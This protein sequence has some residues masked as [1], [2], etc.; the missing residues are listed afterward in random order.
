MS[1]SKRQYYDHLYKI[2][3]IGVADVGKTSLTRVF[4]GDD[5]RVTEV[6]TVQRELFTTYMKRGKKSIKI[7][8]YDT[9]GSE[10]YA[11]LT[12]SYLRA[13]SGILLVY[14]VNN[15]KSLL[16]SINLYKKIK[17]DD[18]DFKPSI[19]LVGSKSDL[20]VKITGGDIMDA[21]RQ[22]NNI[23]HVITSAKTGENL[24][25]IFEALIDDILANDLK[26]ASSYKKLG[27][28]DGGETSMKETNESKCC[29]IL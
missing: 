14:S 23:S 26:L 22:V 21:K 4:C 16:Q 20:D 6:A 8:I 28:T 29:V 15:P 1:K 24:E 25:Y 3:V 27:T 19:I 10:R 18:P 5:F 11:S 13:A 2:V 12:R 9:A 7:D 17:D